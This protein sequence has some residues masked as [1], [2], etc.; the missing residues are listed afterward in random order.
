[1]KLNDVETNEENVVCGEREEGLPWWREILVVGTETAS[2]QS[3]LALRFSDHVR[4]Y[5]TWQCSDV[6]FFFF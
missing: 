2:N 6:F 4:E 1:M 3:G 5:S